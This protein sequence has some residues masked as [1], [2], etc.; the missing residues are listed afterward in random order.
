MLGV[1]LGIITLLAV[2]LIWLFRYLRRRRAK[3][4][5]KKNRHISLPAS[6]VL[7]A[8]SMETLISEETRSQG[9]SRRVRDR[10]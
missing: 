9:G 2:A 4:L 5:R 10:D 8:M 6:D 7:G 1:S 3:N